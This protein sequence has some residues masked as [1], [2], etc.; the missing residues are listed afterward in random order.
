MQWENGVTRCPAAILIPSNVELSPE[1]AAAHAERGS[2]PCG[3]NWRARQ[4]RGKKK[5]GWA[6]YW[7]RKKAEKSRC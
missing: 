7:A 1:D 3:D 2:D 5:S 4:A 6:A